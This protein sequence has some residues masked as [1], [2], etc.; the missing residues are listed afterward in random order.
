MTSRLTHYC[1]GGP[2]NVTPGGR[3]VVR[4]A[5]TGRQRV[6]REGPGAGERGSPEAREPAA[7]VGSGEAVENPIDGRVPEPPDASSFPFP[8]SFPLSFPF[9]EGS[10]PAL[11]FWPSPFFPSAWSIIRS[12]K[13]S[14]LRAPLAS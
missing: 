6:A 2:E 7:V 9:P 11:P 1:V 5:G 4:A 13:R 12:Q 14:R 8:S 10:S 3:G